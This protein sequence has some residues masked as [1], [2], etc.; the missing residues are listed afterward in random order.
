LHG[1]RSAPCDTLPCS[2]AAAR[3]V[4][5]PTAAGSSSAAATP[6]RQRAT[7]E[8]TRRACV[9]VESVCVR[10]CA[11]VCRPCNTGP[12]ESANQGSGAAHTAV[13][14]CCS[15]EPSRSP[16][17]PRHGLHDH[18]CHTV[19]AAPCHT[20]ACTR[21]ALLQSRHLAARSRLLAAHCTA[22][23]QMLRPTC[24]GSDAQLISTNSSTPTT[25]AVPPRQNWR[26]LPACTQHKHAPHS[27]QARPGSA[28]LPSQPNSRRSCAE[29][30]RVPIPARTRRTRASHPHGAR[31]RASCEGVDA[32]V[33]LRGHLLAGAQAARAHH[34]AAASAERAHLGRGGVCPAADAVAAREVAGAL[35]VVAAVVDLLLDVVD[36]GRARVCVCVWVRS[37]TTQ[38]RQRAAVCARA[39]MCVHVC[40]RH[41]ARARCCAR[42]QTATLVDHTHSA[43]HARTH[44]AP[45]TPRT[46][47]TS[48]AL[49]TPTAP[50]QK[51][52]TMGSTSASCAGRCML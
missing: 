31:A 51:E 50:P 25:R 44:T 32:W 45:R 46:S 40:A 9:C 48:S 20:A 27:P 29:Q 19:A 21:G 2:R 34:L 10:V 35:A 15:A 26:T 43:T 18:T 1:Q 11:C 28:H 39:W 4:C 42:R 13:T 36:L 5:P 6:R 41:V 3:P 52:A 16:V 30:R 7:S 8:S 22:T 23:P 17:T 12:R 33:V 49:T 38:G 47:T 37:P 14:D 24:T